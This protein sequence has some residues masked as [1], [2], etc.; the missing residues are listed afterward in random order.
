LGIETFVPT[1]ILRRRY[2][3]VDKQILSP[4]FGPYIFAYFDP[5]ND[6]WAPICHTPGVKKLL[7]TYDVEREL[8]IPTPIPNGLVENLMECTSFEPELHE[9]IIHPGCRVRVINGPFAKIAGQ[10]SVGICTWARNRRV[11]LLLEIMQGRVEVQFDISAVE[12]IEE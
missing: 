4:L 5:E 9:R 2:Y 8:I 12:R 6:L 11:A 10:E 7:S 1:E 3:G